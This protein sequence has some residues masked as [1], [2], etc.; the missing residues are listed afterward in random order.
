MAK[1]LNIEL[2]RLYFLNVVKIWQILHG[3]KRITA[4]NEKKT[5]RNLEIPKF[6][7]QI[8]NFK[9]LFRCSNQKANKFVKEFWIQQPN[10]EIFCFQLLIFQ[11]F[12]WICWVLE[13]F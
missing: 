11:I 4:N 3:V 12:I 5:T 6:G 1:S 9:T 7:C 13:L 10:F 2:G 8:R